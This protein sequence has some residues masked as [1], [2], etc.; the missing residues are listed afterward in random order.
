MNRGSALPRSRFSSGAASGVVEWAREVVL[1]R[2]DRCGTESKAKMEAS[3]LSVEELAG[4]ELSGAELEREP[5]RARPR[6]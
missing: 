3:I 2:P 5:H 6:M 1:F 4:V